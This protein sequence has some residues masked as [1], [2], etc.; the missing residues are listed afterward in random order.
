MAVNIERL[1]DI[2]EPRH[3]LIFEPKPEED[4]KKI[5]VKL[6]DSFPTLGRLALAQKDILQAVRG[7]CSSSACRAEAILSVVENDV[8]ECV[9]EA[10]GFRCENSYCP[11]EGPG[12]ADVREPRRPLPKDP[13]LDEQVL[14]AVL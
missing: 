9:L 2:K 3:T 7:G 14:V 12:G 6:A 4:F 11:L 13:T 10:A 5:E 1:F 8:G